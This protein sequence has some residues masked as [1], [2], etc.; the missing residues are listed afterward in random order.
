MP[1]GGVVDGVMESGEQGSNTHLDIENHLGIELIKPL[2]YLT[3]ST[4]KV[5]LGS[6]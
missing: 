1:Q 4:L 3:Y 2:K 5:L 6:L